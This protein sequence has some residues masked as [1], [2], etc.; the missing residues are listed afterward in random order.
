MLQRGIRQA[1]ESI[2][3]MTSVE[4]I[5]QFTQIEQEEKPEE[6]NALSKPAISWPPQG[7]IEFKNF[8]LRYS[9]NAEPILKNI[10]FVIEPSSKVTLL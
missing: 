3:Q 9:I 4:R 6:A 2:T 1:A 8:N 5:F 7:K 10:N